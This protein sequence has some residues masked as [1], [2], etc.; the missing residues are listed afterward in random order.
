[1]TKKPITTDIGNSA[2]TKALHHL[3]TQGLSLIERNFTCR[4][5]EIDLIMRHADM[6]VFVEVRFR[7]NNHYGSPLETVV[8]SKQQKI[9]TTAQ[10]FLLVKNIGESMPVRFDV[11]GILP[12]DITWVQNAF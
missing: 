7:K 6:L 5:G 2:E 11:I 8:A 3:E 4:Y 12:N 1:M 9:R 10:H